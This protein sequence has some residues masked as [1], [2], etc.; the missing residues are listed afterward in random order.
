M[1][2]TIFYQISKGLHRI[3]RSWCRFIPDCWFVGTKE[4][5]Q[6]NHDHICDWSNGLYWC[7]MINSIVIVQYYFITFRRTSISSGEVHFWV[8]D[9][10]KKTNGT[11]PKISCVLE[12]ASLDYKRAKI[13]VPPK[14]VRTLERPEKF[15]LESEYL[16]KVLPE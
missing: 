15:Y 4:Y 9:H 5:L 14:R 2:K 6:S 8:L 1:C 12:K 16:L 11:G 13:K 10:R 7:H 3:R